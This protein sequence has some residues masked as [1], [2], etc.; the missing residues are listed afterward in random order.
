M[1]CKME[2][3]RKKLS[4]PLAD[5][6]SLTKLRVFSIRHCALCLPFLCPSLYRY[7]ESLRWL[8][9]YAF[10]YMVLHICRLSKA[11]CSVS[12][13]ASQG[14]SK[15]LA[16]SRAAAPFITGMQPISLRCGKTKLGFFVVDIVRVLLPLHSGS[17]TPRCCGRA[18]NAVGNPTTPVFSFRSSFDSPSEPI[19]SVSR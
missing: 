19:S 5:R 12:C 15:L 17:S 14:L 3:V 1:M 10:T 8:L 16:V 13:W 11:A 4:N 9:A 2:P 6:E 18:E 7:P